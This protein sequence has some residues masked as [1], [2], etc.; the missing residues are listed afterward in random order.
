VRAA[1]WSAIAVVAG[2][3]VHALASPRVVPTWKL[4]A[5]A[6]AGFVNEDYEK[7]AERYREVVERSPEDAEGLYMYAVCLRRTGVP[8]DAYAPFAEKAALHAGAEL[9]PPILGFLA[10][11]EL[12]AGRLDRA[13]E[14]AEAW[15]RSRESNAAALQLVAEIELRGARPDL[16]RA[17]A[18]LERARAAGVDTPESALMLADVSLRVYGPLAAESG[19]MPQRVSV[20]LSDALSALEE[21]AAR[22][23]DP[24]TN[25]SRRARLLLAL[26]RRDEA[27]VAAD[28]ALTKL[29]SDAPEERRSEVRLLRAMAL[30][31]RGDRSGATADIVAALQGSR[32]A[33]VAATAAAFLVAAGDADTAVGLLTDAAVQDATGAVRGVLAALLL[34]TGRIPE[35]A[36]AIDSARALAPGV[37]SYAET[38]GAIAVAQGRLEAAEAAYADA[39]RLAPTLVGPRVGRVLAALAGA[40]AAGAAASE[41]AVADLQALRSE[42]GDDPRVLAALGRVLLSLGRVDEACEALEKAKDAAPADASLWR[43]LAAARRRSKAPDAAARAAEAYARARAAAAD[44]DVDLVVAETEARLDAGED[45]AAVAVCTEHLRKKPDEPAVL[46]LRAQAYRR[47]AMWPSAAADL[48]KLTEVRSDDES[49]TAQLVDSLFRA[50]DAAGARR[51]V[52]EAKPRASPE[53]VRVL[54]FLATLHGG[55]VAQ[56]LADL[57][58][59]GPTTL[60]AEVQLAA[61]RRDE[62]LET[63]RRV[64][65]DRS[66]DVHAARL[67][68]LVLVDEDPPKPENVAEAR[69][70]APLPADAPAGL[71]ALLDG[72]LLLAEGKAAEAADR[73][74]AAARDAPS[75]AFAA[76]YLGEA[77]SRSG[78]GGE[79]LACFRRAA[80]IPGAPP[81][82]RGIAAARLLAAASETADDA[83]AEALVREAL[84]LTPDDSAAAERLVCLLRSRGAWTEAADAAEHALGAPGLDSARAARLRCLAASARLADDRAADAAVLLDGLDAAAR[85]SPVAGLLRGFVALAERRPDAADAE[86]VAVLAADPDESAAQSGRVAAALAA[87]RPDAATALHAEWRKRFPDDREFALTSVRLFGRAGRVADAASMAEAALAASPADVALGAECARALVAA[88][89]RKDAV[90]A[91]RGVAARVPPAEKAACELRLGAFLLGAPGLAGDA[92]GLARRVAD[93]SDPGGL[94]A[95]EAR[96]LESE[97]LLAAGRTSEAEVAAQA[98]VRRWDRVVTPP[99]EERLEARVRFVLGT[100]AS[101]SPR[102]HGEATRHL[103]RCLELAPSDEAATNNLAWLLSRRSGGAVEGAALAKRLTTRAP[104]VPAYWDTR[105]ACSAAVDDDADAESSWRRAM[106][107]AAAA[108][109]AD[110]VA[111]A[112]TALRY[113]R[114]LASRNRAAD[115]RRVAA[116]ALE[117][118]KGAEVEREVRTFLAELGGG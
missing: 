38:Q 10:H 9:L 45:A 8:A 114:F 4:K 44:D 51:V 34:K 24:A 31:A 20:V 105:A 61:G 32:A 58:R 12:E 115:A 111:R 68:V 25:A 62:A 42:F 101:A 35:A 23:D 95:L 94:V 100:A 77:L 71:G 47:L 97:A 13:L 46:E 55:D 72:R 40:R 33:R 54:D 70:A 78:R 108:P 110:S 92:L 7:A 82:L 67:L 60:L 27:F 3:V 79:S 74:A 66:G 37:A 99:A 103:E 69:A 15:A 14:R 80:S 53:T 75:D 93:A 48:R 116:Q 76:L 91:F 117:L 87:G 107:L 50:N 89:R 83:A 16:P 104:G 43:T 102:R 5:D 30:H 56:A 106:D 96:V 90:A 52:A 17:L 65:K 1:K 118:A 49:A 88:G 86:F 41:R 11:C 73:L 39:V 6:H 26:G 63:L 113:A 64:R 28:R 112:R 22:G 85:A 19:R 57:S 98:L 36:A 59:G 18:A 109:D 81:R 84:R 21:I 29:P 2:L